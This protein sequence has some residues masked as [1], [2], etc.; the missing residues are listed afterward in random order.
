MYEF[1]KNDDNSTKVPKKFIDRCPSCMYLFE[2]KNNCEFKK[3]S[4]GKSQADIT[5]LY[6]RILFNG[7]HKEYVELISQ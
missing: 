6:I 1:F 5:E 3:C 7:S 2:F 4:C